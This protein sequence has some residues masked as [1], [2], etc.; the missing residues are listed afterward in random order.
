MASRYLAQ[1]KRARSGIPA[2]AHGE[3]PP[4]ECPPRTGSPGLG[5]AG[6]PPRPAREG[7]PSPAGPAGNKG[8]DRRNR[9]CGQARAAGGRPEVT[10]A[11]FGLIDAAEARAYKPRPA[12]GPAS[13]LRAGSVRHARSPRLRRCQSERCREAHLSTVQA[14]PQAPARLSRADGDGRRPQ[15]AG[16]PPRERP[17]APV[18][19]AATEPAGDGIRSAAPQAP[20]RVSARRREWAKGA[21]AGRRPAGARA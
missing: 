4:G 8:R 9:L 21:H 6:Q 12:D 1:V 10:W 15:G 3:H 11:A 14:R 5:R 2:G 13:R 20:C 18:G 17:Q 16:Q 7:R 19:L